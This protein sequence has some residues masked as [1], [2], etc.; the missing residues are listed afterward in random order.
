MV[1]P[2]VKKIVKLG[3]V[4]LSHRSPTLGISGRVRH[5]DVREACL[6]LSVLFCREQE[7]VKGTMRAGEKTLS[8]N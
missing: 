6:L 7:T 5:S 1:K 3:F 8:L 4:A 2:K